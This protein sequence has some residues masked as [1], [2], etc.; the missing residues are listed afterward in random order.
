MLL[1]YSLR[2]EGFT[3]SECLTVFEVALRSAR[4]FAPPG[5]AERSSALAERILGETGMLEGN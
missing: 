2:C 5:E 4:T 3:Q 1:A